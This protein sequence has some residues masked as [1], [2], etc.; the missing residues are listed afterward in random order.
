MRKRKEDMLGFINKRLTVVGDIVHETL[1]RTW[2]CSCECGK[3][4]YIKESATL[5]VVQSCGCLRS[6]VTALRNKDRKKYKKVDKR[7]YNMWKDMKSRSSSREFCDVNQGW[8]SFETFQE[9]VLGHS[10]YS[11]VELLCRKLDRGDYEPSNVYFGTAKDNQRDTSQDRAKKEFTFSTKSFVLQ[12]KNLRRFCE[13][14]ELDVRGMQR[15]NSGEYKEYKG[16]SICCQKGRYLGSIHN[17]P[18]GF[19]VKLFEGR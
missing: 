9:F 19:K 8:V 14:Y 18:N 11:G 13:I 16:F 3:T 15:L 12:F 10:D 2:V 1:G 6:E 4:H 5:K 7:V 17:E